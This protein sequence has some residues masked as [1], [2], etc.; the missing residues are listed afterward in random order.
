MRKIEVECQITN[1][2]SFSN[3]VEVPDTADDGE[4]QEA[5]ERHA[6][7]LNWGDLDDMFNM[8][9]PPEFDVEFSEYSGEQSA[10]L[11]LTRGEL[12]RN[13]WREML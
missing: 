5:L 4:I 3:I 10:D 7:C 12:K 6:E 2:L 8:E 1:H 11:Q 9:G 13:P